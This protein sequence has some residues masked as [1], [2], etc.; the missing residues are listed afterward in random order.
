MNAIGS[1]ISGLFN[2]MV[3]PFGAG[4]TMALIALSLLSGAMMAFVF[5]YTSNPKAIIAAKDKVKARILEMRIY[6]DDPGLIIRAFGG[7]LKANGRYLATL[8]VPFV[9]I[10][11]PIMIVWMQLDER[12]ARTYLPKGSTTL[13]TVQLKEGFD[14][15]ETNVDLSIAGRGIVKD[16]RPVRVS[17][18]REVD[19]RLKVNHWG[20][21]TATLT[22]DGSSYTI[23]L[24]AQSKYRFVGHKR[25]ASSF[26]EPLLHPALDPIPA[27]SPFASVRVE[28]PSASYAFLIWHVHWIVIFL[29]Y[30]ALAAIILKFVI[31]FEI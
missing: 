30:S 17:E 28:Y 7:T 15:Y 20:T 25:E 14:P 4:H 12:Y 19:W 21:H 18:T 26:M 6:Q 9:V 2:L 22:A 27:G 11:I 24:V 16:S 31:H 1:G 8:L 3:A 29:V 10:I 23:P 5:K 13:L